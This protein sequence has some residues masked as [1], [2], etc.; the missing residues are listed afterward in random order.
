M[1]ESYKRELKDKSLGLACNLFELL[2][3]VY[4]SPVLPEEYKNICIPD[5]HGFLTPIRMLCLDDSTLLQKGKS[6]KFIHPKIRGK[7][8]TIL[9]VQSKLSG[10]LMHNYIKQWR[11]FGQKE[12]LSNRIKRILLQ[13]PLSETVLK[14]MLQNADDAKAS[15]VMFI[16]D[17]NTYGSE[18][19]FDS[20][21]EPLQGIALLVYDNNHFTEK[22]IAGIQHLGRGTK[23]SDPTKTGQYG[24]GFNAVYHITDVPSFLSKSPNGI[25]DT[26]CVMDP[27]CKYAPG[28]DEISPGARFTELH[29]LRIPFHDVFKCYH[30]D[31]LLKS[32]GTVF[33]LPLL[34]KTFAEKS[35]LSNKE[36]TEQ[37]IYNMLHN[38]E[39]EISKSL[40][41]LRN[42]RKITIASITKGKLNEK[43][44][45]E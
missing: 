14:E 31:I 15:E 22:D 34:T 12:E 43:T 1:S 19:I 3:N 25:A 11:P 45:T 17:F 23:E 16:T 10:S 18:K 33:R 37:I 27:N 30:E 29:D 38:L 13:Y 20:K 41:F 35:E 28:A 5:E 21:W 42:V 8:A 7:D 2:A 40:L 6:L 36:V 9:G 32:T 4:N 24:V 39:S 44:C 26:L